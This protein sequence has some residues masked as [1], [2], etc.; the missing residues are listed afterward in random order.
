MPRQCPLLAEGALAFSEEAC[1]KVERSLQGVRA[2]LKREQDRE[3]REQKK[4]RGAWKLTEFFTKVVL[5]LFALSSGSCECPVAFLKQH[6]VS[7]HWP[8]QKDEELTSLVYNTFL[9]VEVDAY[10]DLTDASNSSCPQAMKVAVRFRSLYAAQCWVKG[11]NKGKGIAPPSALV[12]AKIEEAQ[13]KYPANFAYVNLELLCA[14]NYRVLV[15]RWRRTFQNRYGSIRRRDALTTEE[16]QSRAGAS[17][18]GTS[19]ATHHEMRK[20]M[21]QASFLCDFGTCPRS[22]P[23]LFWVQKKGPPAAPFFGPRNRKSYSEGVKKRPENRPQV[24]P[25]NRF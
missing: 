7:R 15:H 20:G 9:E 16:M 12:A 5:I 4:I 18:C 24:R 19:L 21:F 14:S 17:A 6:G 8:A 3:R 11:L 1:S 25:G 13:R 23:D 2:A 10:V 22:V